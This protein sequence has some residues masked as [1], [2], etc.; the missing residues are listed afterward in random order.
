MNIDKPY[1]LL[2]DPWGM[3]TDDDSGFGNRL[4]CW[5][6]AQILR[7]NLKNNY[8]I[9]V[10]EKEYPETNFLHFPN[11]EVY[12][13]LH[14]SDY[15]S[16]KISIEDIN[17]FTESKKLDIPNNKNYILDVPYTSFLQITDALEDS[18]ISKF[19]SK[20]ELFN[21][22]LEHKIKEFSEN[23]I[24]IH[25]R[26]GN[27]V[28]IVQ[29]DLDSIPDGYKDFYKICPECDPVYRFVNDDNFYHIIDTFL[30]IYDNKEFY[31]SIDVDDNAVNYYKTRFKNKIFTRSDFIK[32]NTDTIRNSMLFEEVLGLKKIGIN[33]IDFFI[34][35]NTEF[36]VRDMT[37]SWSYLASLIGQVPS[38]KLNYNPN[39]ILK[40]YELRNSRKV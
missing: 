36:I 28:N 35:A 31:L 24:G 1:I 33:L 34:L 13:T 40:I 15:P 14:G 7:A 16:K 26:R 5:M 25:I 37:S 12:K 3:V 9:K 32:N 23:K 20:I 39:D 27:G 11:T 8:S 17:L 21:Q 29:L 22:T 18:Y 6:G 10:L 30:Q 19:V 38:C 2:R 4:V